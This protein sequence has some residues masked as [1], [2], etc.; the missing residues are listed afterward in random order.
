VPLYHIALDGVTLDL[1]SPALALGFYP[2]E[3]G[4]DGRL[5]RWS[6]DV[7][8]FNLGPSDQ[9]RTLSLLAGAGAARPAP[10]PWR[11]SARLS[12]GVP[13]AVQVGGRTFGG[14]VAGAA[15]P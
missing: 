2:I 7:A 8:F 5:W 6:A 10:T 11:W 3:R 13:G 4:N 9:A 12:T 14:A 15:R 1:A